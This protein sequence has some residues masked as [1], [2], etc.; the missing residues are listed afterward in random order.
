M[1]AVLHSWVGHFNEQIAGVA[2]R[3]VGGDVRQL[4][5]ALIARG[6]L[7]RPAV[8]PGGPTYWD[9]LMPLPNTNTMAYTDF[10]TI[11]G[12]E[13]AYLQQ[14]YFAAGVAGDGLEP[15]PSLE[16]AIIIEWCDGQSFEREGNTKKKYPRRYRN[17]V[18]VDGPFHEMNH[19]MYGSVEMLWHEFYCW[20][21]RE[22]QREKLF[23]MC[24]SL[25]HNAYFNYLEFISEVFVAIEAYLIL[26]VKNPPPVRAVAARPDPQ[27]YTKKDDQ[28]T[29]GE[30]ASQGSSLLSMP[31][32]GTTVLRAGPPVQADA[33]LDCIWLP[34]VSVGLP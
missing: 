33:R 26:D 10:I 14:K 16:D 24:Q 22:W 28:E 20:A 2:R 31:L 19:F 29:V 11:M 23:E 3:A 18:P 12:E 15:P 27:A 34:H 9:A 8:D 32:H 13:E 5:L 30:G 6:Y 25:A 21:A 1:K 17:H 4:N 7:G